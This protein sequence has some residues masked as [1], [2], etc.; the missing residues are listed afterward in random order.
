M[1]T[2][3]VRRLGRVEYADGLAMQ[4]LLVEARARALVPDTLLLLEHPR[5]ITLGRGARA[6]NV[7]WPKEMLEARGFELYETDRG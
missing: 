1:R 6:Q 2:L 4:K 7:L 3:H 5:V